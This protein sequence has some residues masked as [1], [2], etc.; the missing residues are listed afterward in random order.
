[1]RRDLDQFGD[2]SRRIEA[3]LP[4]I[5]SRHAHELS[6]L[7]STVCKAGSR[8]QRDLTPIAL[9]F[10]SIQQP[11]SQTPLDLFLPRRDVPAALVLGLLDQR[12]VGVRLDE[13]H[14]TLDG[15][16]VRVRPLRWNFRNWRRSVTVEPRR[17]QLAGRDLARHDDF[18][19]ALAKKYW[20]DFSACTADGVIH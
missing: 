17:L 18:E 2:E 19:R 1:H 5:Q 16:T 9:R 20:R 14:A 10:E 11:V 3:V 4:P 15:P 8:H 7:S 6:I 13:F 12:D